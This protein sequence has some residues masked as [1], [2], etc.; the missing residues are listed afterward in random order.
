[1]EEGCT[2]CKRIDLVL[3]A[4]KNTKKHKKKGKNGGVWGAGVGCKRLIFVV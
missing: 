2:G 1:M 4:T 3:W